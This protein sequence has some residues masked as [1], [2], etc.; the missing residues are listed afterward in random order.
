MVSFWFRCC[1]N[2]YL[3]WNVQIFS[4][5]FI[6]FVSQIKNV[7]LTGKFLISYNVT[8][9][10]TNTS[11]QENIG[12]A[13]NLNLN[14]DPYLKTIPF[15]YIKNRFL[16]SGKYYNQTDVVAISSPFGSCLWQ[17]KTNLKDIKNHFYQTTSWTIK[18]NKVWRSACCLD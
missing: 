4:Q 5:C 8:N 1:S 3:S 6:S 13:I 11:L 18:Q 12:T 7:S 14:N 17:I 16:F 9:L 2:L 10:I 15:C